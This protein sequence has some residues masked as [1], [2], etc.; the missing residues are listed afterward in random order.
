MVLHSV[1][2]FK[3][4]TSQKVLKRYIRFCK[5]DGFGFTTSK[6]LI[7]YSTED[8]DR[9]STTI[10]CFKYIFRYVKYSLRKTVITQR[11]NWRPHTCTFILV[12]W[13]NCKFYI[14]TFLCA[15]NLI[16]YSY[17]IYEYVQSTVAVIFQNTK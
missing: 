10:T 11:V 17:K 13:Q 15:I 7:H 6:Y 1:V 8:R 16:K 5:N 12:W 9:T 4:N 14:S 3:E 2:I